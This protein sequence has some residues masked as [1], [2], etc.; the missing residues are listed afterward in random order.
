MNIVLR[1]VAQKAHP[2]TFDVT[3]LSMLN[4]VAALG[5]NRF[6]SEEEADRD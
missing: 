2:L 1:G 6:L 5:L 4:L 3:V